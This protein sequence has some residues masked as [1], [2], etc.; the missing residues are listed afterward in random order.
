MTLHEQS[1][2]LIGNSIV[3]A[4]NV[5]DSDVINEHIYEYVC[6]VNYTSGQTREVGKKIIKKFMKTEWGRLFLNYRKGNI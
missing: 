5:I 6:Q 4:N 2:Q 3:G 1:Y